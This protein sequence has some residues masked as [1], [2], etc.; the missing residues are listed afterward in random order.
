MGKPQ[1]NVLEAQKT[2]KELLEK[3]LNKIGWKEKVNKEYCDKFYPNYW[4]IFN[5]STIIQHSDIFR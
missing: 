4:E 2:S 3:H 1:S 5:L